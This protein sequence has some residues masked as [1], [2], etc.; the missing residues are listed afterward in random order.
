MFYHCLLRQVE[1]LPSPYGD[2]DSS[3]DYVQSK[4]LSDCQANYVIGKCNCKEVHM[5]GQNKTCTEHNGFC[6]LLP[7]FYFLYAVG[8]LISLATS[9]HGGMNL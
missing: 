9:C 8:W 5:R 6:L 2:C 7:E 4:C 3:E 1:E